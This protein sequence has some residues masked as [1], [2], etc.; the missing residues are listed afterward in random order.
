MKRYLII[1]GALM[2][3]ISILSGCAESVTEPEGTGTLKV[4]LTDAP[5]DFDAV[6]VTFSEISAHIDS[7]WVLI[8]G[9][10][11]TVNLLD[12]TNGRFIEIGSAEVPAG[13]YTQIRLSIEMADVVMEGTTHELIVPSSTQTGLKLV[14]EFEIEADA[15]LEVMIDFDAARSVVVTGTTDEPLEYMLV[16]TIRVISPMNSE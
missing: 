4:M 2:M 1:A 9:E 12:L 10:S 11:V 14:T 8:Q 16:P 5:G 7:A 6:N 3:I 13:K 15:T